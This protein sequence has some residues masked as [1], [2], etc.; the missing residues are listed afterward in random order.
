MDLSQ[1]E[2]IIAIAEEKNIA[3]AA[4]RKFLTQ[5]ALNQQL[6]RLEKELGTP[7][8]ER[9]YHS[10]ELTPAG[11]AYIMTAREMLKMKDDTYKIIQDIARNDAGEISIAFTPEKGAIFFADVYTAFREKYPKFTFRTYEARVPRIMQLL[12]K[13]EITY[14]LITYSEHN[15]KE[16]RLDYIDLA[17]EYLILAMPASHPLAYLAR[18]SED[19]LPSID[20]S[21]LK[22]EQ[23]IL[24][25]KNT[26]IRSMIDYILNTHNINPSIL[27]ETGSSITQFNMVRNGLGIAF[28]PQSYATPTDGIVYFLPEPHQSWMRAIAYKK[29]TYISKAEKYLIELFKE[30]I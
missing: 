19:E 25:S 7:L 23:Y 12:L 22:D 15:I 3:R 28:L 2:N 14:G 18:E 11:N 26:N 17:R 13:Q 1:L 24:A 10:L 9:K 6:L 20:M 27:I 4:E 16:S 29:G 21:L 30:L 8:F 5:S